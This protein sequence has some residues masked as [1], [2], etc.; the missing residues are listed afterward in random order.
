M[1]RASRDVWFNEKVEGGGHSVGDAGAE[2]ICSN[3]SVFRAQQQQYS[4]WQPGTTI[5]Q[6]ILNPSLAAIAGTST[7]RV[8]QH[9]VQGGTSGRQQQAAAAAVSAGQHSGAEEGGGG[10]GSNGGGG[11]GG[12]TSAEGYE[13]GEG[14]MYCRLCK[15]LFGLKQAPI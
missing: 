1:H 9:G 12:E 15:A 14:G 8:S 5:S 7:Q 4:D 10:G 6:I 3:T 13:V 11:Q 2:G